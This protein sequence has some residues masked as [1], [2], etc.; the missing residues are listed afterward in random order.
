MYLILGRWGLRRLSCTGYEAVDGHGLPDHHFFTRKRASSWQL[1]YE[2]LGFHC[3]SLSFNRVLGV[4]GFLNE[5]FVDG[6]VG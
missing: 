4:S 6:L 1:Y 3:R 2:L 5:G